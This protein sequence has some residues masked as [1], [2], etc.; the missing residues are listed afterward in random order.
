[1]KT[2]VIRAGQAAG[3][4]VPSFENDPYKWFTGGKK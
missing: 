4:V 3:P 1:M 2:I